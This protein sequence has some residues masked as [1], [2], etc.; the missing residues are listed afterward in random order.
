MTDND[1]LGAAIEQHVSK[2]EAENKK[3]REEKYDL[4]KQVLSLCDEVE[5]KS[6]ELHRWENMTAEEL[7]EMIAGM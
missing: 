2:L 6:I 3:L 1:R 5:S 7:G 4:E